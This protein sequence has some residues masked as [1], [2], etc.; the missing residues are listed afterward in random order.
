MRPTHFAN[1]T[2]DARGDWYQSW[3]QPL[4]RDS[5][6][7]GD[8]AMRRCGTGVRATIT[9]HLDRVFRLGGRSVSALVSYLMAAHLLTIGICLLLSVV[10]L[11]LKVINEATRLCHY[12]C[13]FARSVVVRAARPTSTNIATAGSQQI[14]SPAGL[15]SPAADTSPAG[16]RVAI[17]AGENADR[18]G[19]GSTRHLQYWKGAPVRTNEH[20]PRRGN[21]AS[22]NRQNFTGDV[23]SDFTGAPFQYWRQPTAQPRQHGFAGEDHPHLAG[24]AA[25]FAGEGATHFDEGSAM[26][27]PASFSAKSK[28][29]HQG[30]AQGRPHGFASKGHQRFAG[31]TTVRAGEDADRAGEGST[32]LARHPSS[33]PPARAS[34]PRRRDPRKSGLPNKRVSKVRLT[35]CS[36]EVRTRCMTAAEIAVVIDAFRRWMGDWRMTGYRIAVDDVWDEAQNFARADGIELPKR[37]RFLEVLAKTQGIE[38]EYDVRLDGDRKVTVY[39][40]GALAKHVPID[41]FVEP[42]HAREGRADGQIRT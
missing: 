28:E 5:H 1:K 31:E 22:K 23:A 39:T 17:I 34:R 2:H 3:Y 19:K 15:A 12:V 40:F 18:V 14:P 7:S 16:G 8:A 4:L 36:K 42:A 21:R 20:G 33:M 35:P 26:P 32:M 37:D 38:R 6:A 24:E 10:W 27:L 30:S 25:V 9:K 11:V 29:C 13:S 41:R